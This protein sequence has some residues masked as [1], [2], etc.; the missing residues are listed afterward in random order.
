M[1]KVRT[2]AMIFWATLFV[3]AFTG[4]PNEAKS[5]PTV[6]VTNINLADTS[7]SNSGTVY[8]NGSGSDQPSSV[9]L[10]ATVVPTN[11]S[12]K[13]VVWTVEG[14]GSTFINWNESTRTISA[15]AA[16]QAT[17]KVTTADG[18]FSKSYTVTVIDAAAAP[19]QSVSISPEAPLA[20][21]KTGD[22]AF[23]P[24]NTQLNATVLPSTATQGVTWSV[25]PATG[26]VSV[27]STG[28]VTPT[29]TATGT[30]VITATST[31]DPTKTDTI[32][33]TVTVSPGGGGDPVTE[34]NITGAQ[35][36]GEY[37]YL[38]LKT[39]STA[40]LTATVNQN[41]ANQE[42]NWNSS[43]TSGNGAVTVTDGELTAGNA[44]A[45]AGTPVWTIITA[46]SDEDPDIKDTVKVIVL[47][48]VTDEHITGENWKHAWSFREPI[49]GW[50]VYEASN[51][52]NPE[53]SAIQ[54][55]TTMKTPSTLSH[56]LTIKADDVNIRWLPF[57]NT[58]ANT[59]S[60]AIQTTEAS[61]PVTVEGSGSTGN[62]TFD[63]SDTERKYFL[64]I[65]D[66]SVPFKI[67][68]Y[69]SN[70]GNNPSRYP[71]VYADGDH[72]STGTGT[73]S[74]SAVNSAYSF[75]GTGES[76]TTV[77]L[78]CSG[79]LRI[80]D[81]VLE[82][83]EPLPDGLSV[84]ATGNKTSV[85]AGNTDP[86]AQ[87]RT[88]QLTA[89]EGLDEVTTGITWYIKDSSDFSSGTNVTTTVATISTT[90]LLTAGNNLASDI[91]I[92]VFVQK[93][94]TVSRGYKVTVEKWSSPIIFSWTAGDGTLKLANN[95]PGIPTS[96]G[97]AFT[98]GGEDAVMINSSNPGFSVTAD[99][100]ILM[101]GRF[102]IG[103]NTS[104]NAFNA[105][106]KFDLS[107]K[108]KVTVILTTTGSATGNFRIGVNSNSS[109]LNDGPLAAAGRFQAVPTAL[110]ADQTLT[111]T[112]DFSTASETNK[113][114]LKNSFITL[115]QE[116]SQNGLITVTS[117]L[118]EY[119]D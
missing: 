56:G 13:A 106:G 114:G 46:A 99:G 41:A 88:L 109:G 111:A 65:A 9:T 91:D 93:D 11:A 10:V 25:E 8:I 78:G 119:V 32:N 14:D 27:S 45:N 5:N 95:N 24:A 102:A 66:I 15:K 61:L 1:N 19:V 79:G 101:Y 62:T 28:M 58:N 70:T 118:I 89:Y 59:P 6:K 82:K 115:G 38:Y 100:G 47:P 76:T 73:N 81:V 83:I 31:A 60:G 96:N 112:F 43:V 2:A 86:A 21:S 40:T 74:T 26:V 7:G 98:I 67:T 72:I 36:F 20:F 53:Q 4:C 29:A 108:F 64:E 22:G 117:I 110:T 17:V 23:S 34:I 54:T 90:G 77:Q 63:P 92:W 33:V 18:S 87:P 37:K 30:A 3:L 42:I 80:Y 103:I 85:T 69:Y 12:N 75:Y 16:G 48:D 35:T 44:T 50:M 94:S 107:K 84:R 55:A 57:Q 116:S 71:I 97:T 105:N 68:L 51:S 52:E 113:T 39:G 49:S 104:T